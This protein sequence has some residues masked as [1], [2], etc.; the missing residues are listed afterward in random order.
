MGSDMSDFREILRSYDPGVHQENLDGDNAIRARFLERFPLERWPTMTLEEYALGQSRPKEDVYCWW[1]EFGTT[2]INIGGA[3]AIKH[4]I[5]LH[6]SGTWKYLNAYANKDAAWEAI[7]I[8][9]LRMFELAEAQ[10]WEQMHAE[11]LFDRGSRTKLKSLYLY[12]PDEI[13]PIVAPQ[14]MQFFLTN[15]GDDEAALKGLSPILLNRRLLERLRNI[16]EAQDM[17]TRDLML[18]LYSWHDPRQD[19]SIA[20]YRRALQDDVAA[21]EPDTSSLFLAIADA[22]ERKG[23]VILHGPPGTGKTYHALRFAQWWLARAGAGTLQELTSRQTPRRVWWVVAN[24]KQWHWDALFEKGSEEY[25]YGRL[26][27][28][29]A[30][31]QPGDLVVGYLASPNRR[32]YALARVTEGLLVRD[33]DQFIT[34]EAVHRIENGL[35]YE[36]LTSDPTLNRSEPMRNRCQGTLFRLEDDEAEYLFS[37]L[38][39]RDP[40]IWEF[41]DLSDFQADMQNQLTLVTFHPSYSYE[42]FIEGFRPLD[43]GDGLRL[44]L[45]DGLFKAVCTAARANPHRKFLVLIDEINRAN[46]AKVFGETITLLERDKR[47]IQVVLPQSKEPFSVPGNVTLLGTMNTSDRSIRLMDAALRRRFG[48]IELM[49]DPALLAGSQIDGQLDLQDFLTVLNQRI[50][51]TQGREKQIGQS[52]FME[53]GKPITDG[54]E[55]ARRFRQEVLPLLQEYCYDDY[56]VLAEYI[57]RGLVDEEDLALRADVLNNDES[58]IRALVELTSEPNGSE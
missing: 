3:T 41:I 15:L 16:P 48:F 20:T 11:G 40:R 34:L 26:R 30:L 1:V 53:D 45:T 18:C 13:L 10:E 36:E 50:S 37:L 8:E 42:D 12:Y 39:E 24:P 7:H 19:A 17:S 51:R 14:H 46:L 55:F 23:Q 35:T 31:V 58:L 43:T 47:G 2:S 6:S 56:G 44:R 4:M 25:R 52:Y 33:G 29:Y 9:F 54:S 38:A 22:L 27:Q 49:P 21:D 32:I 5:F 28:N 57:G